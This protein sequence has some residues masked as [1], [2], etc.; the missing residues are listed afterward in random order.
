MLGGLS[1]FVYAATSVLSTISE[2]QLVFT[3]D[4]RFVELVKTLGLISLNLNLF[5]SRDGVCVHV[6]GTA[7]S[8]FSCCKESRS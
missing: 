3:R 5:H 2:I 6:F 7:Y 8:K 4:V 1:L